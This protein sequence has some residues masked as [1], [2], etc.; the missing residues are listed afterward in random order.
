MKV[1]SEFS[2]DKRSWISNFHH[3]VVSVELKVEVFWREVIKED[4]GV[5]WVEFRASDNNLVDV[6]VAVKF[7][8]L[9]K[10]LVGDGVQVVVFSGK[11]IY[12]TEKV[13]L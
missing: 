9:V 2:S 5:S 1:D 10:I 13:S 11:E 7:T 12:N 6:N 3:E 8:L 4:V